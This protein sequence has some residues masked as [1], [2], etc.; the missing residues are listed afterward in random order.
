MTI[1]D[2]C[3]DDGRDSNPPCDLRDSGACAV[4][5]WALNTFSCVVVDNHGCD[6]VHAD[7]TDLKKCKCLWEITGISQFRD[8]GE[9]C[10]M[11][12]VGEDDIRNRLKPP[13]EAQIWL[14][15]QTECEGP[16]SGESWLGDGNSDHSNHDCSNDTDEAC[17]RIVRKVLQCS[18]KRAE[19]ADDR[20]NHHPDDSA[21]P[22]SSNGIHAD[23]EGENVTAHDKNVEQVLAPANKSSSPFAKQDFSSTCH[24]VNVWKSK[25]ELTNHI[26]RVRCHSTE[27]DEEDKSGDD[28][29]SSYSLWQ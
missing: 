22:V 3:N 19:Q 9:K 12:S 18:W 10:N 21:S 28:T 11:A 7:V 29:D 1:D 6:D 15:P 16:L 20:T 2:T 17:N 14:R 23:R 8:E 24:R 26:S 27:R 5:S 4:E 13:R 25:L